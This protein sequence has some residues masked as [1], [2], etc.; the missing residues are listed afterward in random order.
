M[1]MSENFYLTPP[2]KR[3]CLI[4]RLLC[5]NSSWFY[6]KCFYYI[7]ECS[8]M[9]R[10]GKLSPAD[11]LTQGKN[12][13]KL[14]EDCGGRFEIQGLEHLR[15]PGPLV[16]I[17]NHM[18]LVETMVLPYLI[19]ERHDK[20]LTFVIKDTL[21]KYPAFGTILRSIAAITVG[22]E[23]PRED[24]KKVLTEG[25]KILETGAMSIVI[26][27]QSTRSQDFHPEQFNTIGIK[28]ARAAGV[29]VVPFALKTDFLGNGKFLKDLGPI[30]RRKTLYFHFGAPMPVTGNGKEQ[31]NLIVEFIGQNIR[32]WKEKE[33]VSPQ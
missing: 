33:H 16:F 14:I 27:P 4:D 2:D 7:Y 17:G 21:L 31:H 20:H 30:C 12:I 19:L 6:L 22:R 32:Q 18:S 8:T 28:L 9:P 24:F 1:S 11:F 26:F 15:T 29:P 10:D 13:F 5:G 25:R 3:R 23:N